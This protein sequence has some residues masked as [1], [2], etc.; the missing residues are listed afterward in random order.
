M[1]EHEGPLGD[2]PQGER[3]AAPGDDLAGQPERASTSPRLA[4]VREVNAHL[5]IAGL[6]EQDLAAAL[7]AERAQLAVILAGIGDAVLVVD[8]AGMIVRANVAYTR[9]AGGVDAPLAPQDALG[10]PLPPDQT[11]RTGRAGRDVQPGVHLDGRGREST[12]V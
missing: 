4:D 2:R 9:L 6:R 5:P 10:R 3:G 1:V 12:L 8:Q 11:P 7:E